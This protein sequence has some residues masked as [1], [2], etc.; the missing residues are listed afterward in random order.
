LPL[1]PEPVAHTDGHHKKGCGLAAAKRILPKIRNA[2]PKRPIIIAA[3]GL[4]SDQPFVD[5]LKIRA[6]ISSTTSAT[7]NSH[8]GL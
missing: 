1:A 6:I 4:Y 3:D 2:H 7:V 8:L 5:V